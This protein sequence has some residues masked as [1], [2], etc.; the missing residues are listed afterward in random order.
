MD[1]ATRAV[2]PAASTGRS[3]PMPRVPRVPPTD[4]NS[5]ETHP[6]FC[7]TLIAHNLF[8]PLKYRWNFWHFRMKTSHL[9]VI[10]KNLTSIRQWEMF[11]AIKLN[12]DFAV[13]CMRTNVIR[14]HNSYF[15]RS[16]CIL[17]SL[18]LAWRT[19][20]KINHSFRQPHLLSLVLKEIAAT[21]LYFDRQ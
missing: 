5:T 9:L 10:G 13:G 17:F 12:I 6:N 7:D 19:Q 8:P 3:S 21:K 4:N 1:R 2:D 14:F 15:T 16:N 20:V 18:W 11:Y